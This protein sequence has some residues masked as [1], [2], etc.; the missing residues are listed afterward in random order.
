MHL[1]QC[2]KRKCRPN[3]Y[4]GREGE[5]SERERERERDSER[6]VGREGG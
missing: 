3:R 2:K 5:D 6:N 4:I 1:E